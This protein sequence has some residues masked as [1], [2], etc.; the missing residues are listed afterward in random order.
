[1]HGTG[2]RTDVL[3]KFFERLKPELNSPAAVSRIFNIAFPSASFFGVV[4]SKK[5]RLVFSAKTA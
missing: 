5:L 3:K 2:T 4:V 1:M